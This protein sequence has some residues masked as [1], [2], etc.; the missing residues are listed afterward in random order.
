MTFSGKDSDTQCRCDSLDDVRAF[1]EIGGA[2]YETQVSDD[3]I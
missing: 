2:S 1:H 3:R